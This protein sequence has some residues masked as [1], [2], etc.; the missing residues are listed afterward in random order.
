LHS[1]ASISSQDHYNKPNHA[2]SSEA[3]DPCITNTENDHTKPRINLIPTIIACQRAEIEGVQQ[4][5]VMDIEHI[6]KLPTKAKL[7][8]SMEL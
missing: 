3:V 5:D 1:A 2:G 4:F 6:S 8:S 7:L